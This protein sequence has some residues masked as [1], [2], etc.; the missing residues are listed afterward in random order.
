[1]FAGDVFK[2]DLR[3][4]KRDKIKLVSLLAVILIPLV[5][6][7]MYLWAFW[8]PYDNMK[9]VPVAIVDEDRGIW[10]KNEEVNFG[11]QIVEAILEKKVLDWQEVDR[12]V[13]EEGLNNQEYY[14]VVYI[15]SDFSQTIVSMDSDNPRQASMEWQTKDSTSYIFTTYFRNVM[16]V[17]GQTINEQVSIQMTEEV[18]VK[19][20]EMIEKLSMAG[21]GAAE[22]S[23]GL[24]TL[25][26]G[27]QQLSENLNKAAVGASDLQDGLGNLKENYQK[28]DDGIA[29]AKGGS[30]LLQ[31]GLETASNGSKQLSTGLNDLQEGG[32]LLQEGIDQA[33]DGSD[34]LA[35]GANEMYDKVDVINQ[36]LDPFVRTMQRFGLKMGKY[37]TEILRTIDDVVE[38]KNKFVDGQKQIAEGSSD[39]SDGL[40]NIDKG[41]L[42]LNNGLSSANTGASSLN[43]GVNRLY[44]GSQD[45]SDGLG[46]LKSGST[47]FDSGLFSA[48]KGS[49]DLSSGMLRLADGSNQL[50]KGLSEASTGAETLSKELNNGVNEIQ[51]QINDEK[52]EK[53]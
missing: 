13:A 50:T 16:S 10:Y 44:D 48:Y 43:D 52:I 19:M 32:E 35:S 33:A 29:V 42:S 38:Q 14:A 49:S 1:M 45:L 7:F 18:K 17:L 37:D 39:L 51:N 24:Q 31:S 27:S 36:E 2:N 22:L 40:N 9:N 26:N 30:D 6:G 47:Q 8:D 23:S 53:L 4:I 3:I 28:I 21:E 11:Q 20:D 5:Y 25:D 41:M 34:D 46:E 12:K 15:P